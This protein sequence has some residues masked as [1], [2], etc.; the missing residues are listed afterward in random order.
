MANCA[1]DD[2]L[3]L[4]KCDFGEAKPANAMKSAQISSSWQ[5]PWGRAEQEGSETLDQ[6]RKSY[7]KTEIADI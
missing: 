3:F 2:Y 5:K 4:I 6:Q 7:W 1:R